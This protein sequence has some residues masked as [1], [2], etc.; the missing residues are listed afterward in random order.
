MNMLVH[1]EEN[2]K[3]NTQAFSQINILNSL[4]HNNSISALNTMF[5]RRL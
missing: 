3:Q 4:L 1:M 5:Y 2:Y